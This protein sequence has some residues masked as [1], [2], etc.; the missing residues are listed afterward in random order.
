MHSPT[1]IY[2]ADRVE[3]ESR[4]VRRISEWTDAREPFVDS[5]FEEIFVIWKLRPVI[6][7]SS[8]KEISERLTRR[9]AV[10]PM[11]SYNNN[12]PFRSDVISNHRPDC[13][14]VP[15]QP[16]LSLD[17]G[18][19]DFTEQQGVPRDAFDLRAF[20]PVAR[21]TDD[22]MSDLLDRHALWLEG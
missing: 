7:L 10:L 6:V 20:R 22:S 5:E 14:H 13:V 17:E 8:D 1:K 21:L 15:A 12:L 16:N 2:F 4:D 18:Y 11:F 19:I 9:I 3:G